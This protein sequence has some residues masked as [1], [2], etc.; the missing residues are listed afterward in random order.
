MCAGAF[1][2]N[3]GQ[4]PSAAGLLLTGRLWYGILKKS[5]FFQR[6]ISDIRLACISMVEGVWTKKK[7]KDNQCPRG[8]VPAGR[9]ILL[10]YQRKKAGCVSAGKPARV[11]CPASGG[12]RRGKEKKQ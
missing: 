8:R 1:R 9:V 2:K 5:S 3:T 10:L 11:L 12:R 7:K 6:I 4:G